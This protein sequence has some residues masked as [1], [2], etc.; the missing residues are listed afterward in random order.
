VDHVPVKRSAHI[1]SVGYDQGKMQIS[2][3]NGETYEYSVPSHI[4]KG[5]M[6]A[7]SKGSFFHKFISRHYQGVKI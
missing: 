4:H 6:G 1:V 3:H 2:F 5:L 7:G